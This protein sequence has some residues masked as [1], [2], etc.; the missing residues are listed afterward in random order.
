MKLYQM[1]DGGVLASARPYDIAGGTVIAEG[2]PV[3]LT[4]G[5]V[6][7]AV[8]G[9]T[10]AI[11]GVAAESHSAAADALNPRSNGT[12][13]L[14]Y[15]APG[16]IFRCRAPEVTALSGSAATLE[17]TALKAFAADDFNGG[18]V[19]LVSKAEESTNTDGIGKV[20]RITDFAVDSAKGVLTLE[21]GGTP[22]AGDVYAVFPPVG[23][24]KG[25]LSADGT[26]LSLT[27]A[28]NLPLKVTGHDR[29]LGGICLKAR[30]HVLA[31][32]E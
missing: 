24:A 6:T 10:G 21:S 7:A 14:V 27:A 32:N 22:C 3:K 30:K 9:E 17:V 25:S 8:A 2:Q 12:K 23:F 11:L 4:E 19:K 1:A 15:D 13:I 28:A 16:A 29:D 26:G 20:R 18:Y 5:L 31:E